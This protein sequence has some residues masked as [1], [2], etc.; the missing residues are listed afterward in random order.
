MNF[1]EISLFEGLSTE[2]LRSVLSCIGAA[3]RTYQKGEMIFLCGDEVKT[4][5]I[6]RAGTVK[7]TKEDASG[8]QTTVAVAAEGEV[9]GEVFAYAGVKKSPVSAQA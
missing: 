8:N 1:H 9:F 4:F 6:V 5:G 7:I 2:E 3:D